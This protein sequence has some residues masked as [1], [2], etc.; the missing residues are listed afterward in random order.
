MWGGW[1][2]AAATRGPV[3]TRPADM[4]VLQ[5]P[6]GGLAAAAVAAV[7]LPLLSLLVGW[8]RH[9][10]V[11]GQLGGDGGGDWG[12]GTCREDGGG[13]VGGGR[14]QLVAAVSKRRARDGVCRKLIVGDSAAAAAGMRG[15]GQV[16][17][18]GRGGLRE[19]GARRC[20]RWWGRE[21]QLAAADGQRSAASWRQRRQRR[22]RL[23]KREW[24][25][26]ACGDAGGGGG[27]EMRREYGGDGGD[28]ARGRGDCGGIG[29]GSERLGAG[30]VL[31]L[32]VVAATLGGG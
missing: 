7:P 26:D 22:M 4:A 13:R 9:V 27:R 29:V 31:V 30:R 25:H 20:R 18:F 16:S 32:A 23:M 12:D 10:W 1:G 5:R 21:R 6:C 17:G 28:G 14:R 8:W 2:G 11:E 3:I 19:T 15:K 24:Q